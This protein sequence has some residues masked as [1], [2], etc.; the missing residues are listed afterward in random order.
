MNNFIM[1][2]QAIV[3]IVTIKFIFKSFYVVIF[4]G[5]HFNPVWLVI[6]GGN[7]LAF[8]LRGGKI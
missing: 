1:L 5:F 3:W 7:K 8:E 4:S 2:Y 6:F